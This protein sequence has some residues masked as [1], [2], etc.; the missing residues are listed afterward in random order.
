MGLKKDMQLERPNQRKES[1]SL[2]DQNG[3]HPETVQESKTKAC[4]G[5]VTEQS[6]IG[7]YTDYM[8]LKVKARGLLLVQQ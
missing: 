8:S 7:R 1:F 4:R 6:K 2:Q 5:D 3:R